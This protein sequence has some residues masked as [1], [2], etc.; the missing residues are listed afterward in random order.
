MVDLLHFTLKLRPVFCMQ[1]PRYDGP[2]LD[3]ICPYRFV[4]RI[5]DA[6]F[7]QHNTCSYEEGEMPITSLKQYSSIIP[8]P[9]LF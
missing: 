7:G 3:S 4:K 9:R 8:L 1:Y 6:F 5:D 2:M